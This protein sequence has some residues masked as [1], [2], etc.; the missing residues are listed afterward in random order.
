MFS[1]LVYY[2]L[3]LVSPTVQATFLSHGRKPDAN[4]SS[5][6][7]VVSRRFSYYSSLLVKRCLTIQMRQCEDNLKRKTAHS[8]LPSAAQKGRVLKLPINLTDRHAD[9]LK[10]TLVECFTSS[11]PAFYKNMQYLFFFLFYGLLCTIIFPKS[12]LSTYRCIQAQISRKTSISHG[13]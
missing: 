5:S 4:F 9:V 3:P 7:T 1:S 6:K 8:Q 10:Q 13:P 12:S 2:N 11:S